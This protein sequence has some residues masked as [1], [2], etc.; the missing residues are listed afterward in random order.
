[1]KELLQVPENGDFASAGVVEGDEIISVNGITLRLVLFVLM[2]CL[3]RSLC[4]FL[5]HCEMFRG[6][7]DNISIANALSVI[8][9]KVNQTFTSLLA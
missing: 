4:L 5:S 3:L 7:Q 2:F 9:G 8:T 6:F 1:M